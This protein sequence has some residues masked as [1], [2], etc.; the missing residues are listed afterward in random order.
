MQ[1]PTGKVVLTKEILLN[2][3]QNSR[4]QEIFY[5]I[6]DHQFQPEDSILDD[7]ESVSKMIKGYQMIY[8]LWHLQDE[9]N[10]GGYFQYFDNFEGNN[11][12]K[13]PYYDLTI[14]YLKMIGCIDF[15]SDYSKALEIYTKCRECE[16]DDEIDKIAEGMDEL[17]NKF[18]DNEKVFI[19]AIDEYIDANL[20]DF[21]TIV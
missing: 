20:D 1:R 19:Q 12:I 2:T 5:H 8:M 21:V 10:N 4:Q 15:S 6:C 18:Y 16:D 7:F 14:E 17:D 9:I 11:K 3:P 13:K